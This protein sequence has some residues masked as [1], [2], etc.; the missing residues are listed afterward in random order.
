MTHTDPNTRQAPEN[1]PSG[2]Q[3]G[4]NGGSGMREASEAGN[5]AQAGADGL[6]DGQE[7]RGPIDWA[8]RQQAER[9]RQDPV[10]LPAST[11]PAAANHP[12]VQGRCPACRG[13]SLFLGNG[14]YL[15]CSRL[16]CPDP[17]AGDKLLHGEQPAPGPSA[18][19]ATE[20]QA[21]TNRLVAAL[22]ER[23]VKAGPPPLGTPIARWWDKR[24]AELHN[25]IRPSTDQPEEQ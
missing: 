9:E 17:C 14:G 2:P 19:Q 7:P 4:L 21:L 23:W 15:T 16:N 13:A 20:N 11:A 10:D 22:Y 5:G 3:D 25:A 1:A 8:R 24:L 6:G 18:T 12:L